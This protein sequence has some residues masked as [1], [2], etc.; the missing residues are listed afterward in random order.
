MR[1]VQRMLQRHPAQILQPPEPERRSQLPLL[2]FRSNAPVLLTRFSHARKGLSTS[3]LFD[4]SN[5][6]VQVW[7][8][9]LPQKTHFQ[10]AKCRTF[11]AEAEISPIAIKSLTPLH[12]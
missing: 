11:R 1:R 9:E 7:K 3:V 12:L 5:S 10:T 8:C 6:T 2:I 4:L